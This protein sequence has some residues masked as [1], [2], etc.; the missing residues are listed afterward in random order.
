[1]LALE[2]PIFV[3]NWVLVQES[4]INGGS[5]RSVKMPPMMDRMKKIES[6]N[7]KLKKMHF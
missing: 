6:E 1:V 5:R 4:S 2:I 7:A 3:L